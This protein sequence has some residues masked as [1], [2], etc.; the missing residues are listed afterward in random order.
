MKLTDVKT[1]I[2]RAESSLQASDDDAYKETLQKKVEELKYKI[3]L[4]QEVGDISWID[5]PYELPDHLV[6]EADELEQSI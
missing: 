2:E 6:K 3:C 1:I 5:Y 4:D